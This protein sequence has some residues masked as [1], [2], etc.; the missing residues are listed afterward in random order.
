VGKEKRM[1]KQ[2]MRKCGIR[3]VVKYS[4]HDSYKFALGRI[5]GSPYIKKSAS[6]RDRASQKIIK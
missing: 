2:S 4:K 6:C 5:F 3:R 1:L